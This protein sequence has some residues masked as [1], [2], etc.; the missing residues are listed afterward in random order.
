MKLD[1]VDIQL[2][3]ITAETAGE[4]YAFLGGFVDLKPWAAKTMVVGWNVEV[5]T[6]D[7]VEGES[8]FDR[9][10]AIV[11]YNS[12]GKRTIRL[13][14][15]IT[16]TEAPSIQELLDFARRYEREELV[17]PGFTQAFIDWVREQGIE[18]ET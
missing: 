6:T 7:T 11:S 1:T 5:E 16:R 10:L 14:T 8:D 9:Y 4:G 13:S 12:N 2:D 15:Q 17:P 18:V 3:A